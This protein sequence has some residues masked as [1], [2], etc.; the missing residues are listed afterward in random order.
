MEGQGKRLLLA[1]GLALGVMLVWNM[2]F[3]PKKEEPK[4]PDAALIGAGSGSAPGAPVVVR[5]PPC[6]GESFDLVFPE[7]FVATFSECGGSLTGWRLLEKK[8]EK[9][10]TKGQLLALGV[11]DAGSFLVSFPRSTADVSHQ[12]KWTI[13]EQSKV[14]VKFTLK[15]PFLDLVKTFEVM[16]GAYALRVSIAVTPTQVA[17]DQQ[18]AVSVFAFQDPKGDIHGG[19][20]TAGRAWSSSTLRVGGEQ[21]IET[22]LTDLTNA[23]RHETNVKFTGFEHPYLLAAYAPKRDAATIEK[24]SYALA[25]P[26]GLMRTDL[27]FPVQKLEVGKTMQHELVAYLGPKLYNELKNAER[28]AR[29]SPGFESIVD[30][31]WFGVIGRPLHWLLGELYKLVGNWGIAIMLLT[32]LVKLVTL[33]P[34]T[35]SMRSMKAM[36]GLAPQM[37]VLQEKY[38]DDRQRQQ[39]ET[40]ALYKQHGVNPVAGCLPMLMQ[41]PVWIALYR[42]LSNAGELYREPFINGWISDLTAPD[43]FHVLPVVLTLTMFAQAR[44]T[45]ATGTSAQQKMLQYGMPLGFG[46]MSFF[47]PA[48]L[49]LYIFTNT[50]LGALHSIYMNKFDKKSKAIAA[51]MAA[52]NAAN[53]PAGEKS[54]KAA[55]KAA[56]AKAKPVVDVRDGDDATDDDGDDND[57]SATSAG[58]AGASRPGPRGNKPRNNNKKRSK[59]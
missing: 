7:R 40:M 52:A 36:A 58:S 28:D 51:R 3:P 29:F 21:T 27:L 55:V 11:P 23:P 56:V 13:S 49:T 43:P 22:N 34:V 31:G 47:F 24:W 17:A 20:Q 33:Y 19:T 6:V 57:S 38:K 53:A 42:M 2:V 15:T 46:V 14:G 50:V 37:K 18:L 8:F 30:F 39:S 35:R 44:L 16:P 41:M 59:R 10:A 26:A 54:D 45:P 5:P 48:G 1:V 25:E 4:K 32:F 12:E 9:D